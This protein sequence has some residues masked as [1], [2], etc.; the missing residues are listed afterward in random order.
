MFFPCQAV[1]SRLQ[2]V[3][4]LKPA[5]ASFL[6]DVSFPVKHNRYSPIARDRVQNIEQICFLF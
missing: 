4:G 5:T 6:L 3:Q 1:H 2:Y